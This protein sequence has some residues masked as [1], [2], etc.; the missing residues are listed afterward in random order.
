MVDDWYK[1]LS[2]QKQSVGLLGDLL[3]YHATSKS[4]MFPLQEDIKKRIYKLGQMLEFAIFHQN[5][6]KLIDLV[7]EVDECKQIVHDDMIER[8]LHT[9]SLLLPDCL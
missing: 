1:D 9:L 5:N 4:R 6:D 3:T 7:N 8:I 2:I